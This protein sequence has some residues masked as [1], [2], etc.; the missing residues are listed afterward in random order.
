MY[1]GLIQAHIGMGSS[2]PKGGAGAHIWGSINSDITT[3]MPDNV[4]GFEDQAAGGGDG[5]LT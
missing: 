2:V 5:R 1:T 3:K 4:E